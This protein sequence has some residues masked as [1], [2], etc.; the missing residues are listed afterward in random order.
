MI[1]G[2]QYGT[3]QRRLAD[4]VYFAVRKSVEAQAPG[5][6]KVLSEYH[7]ASLE[8]LAKPGKIVVSWPKA[9]VETSLGA[10]NSKPSCETM[11][12]QAYGKR[13]EYAKEL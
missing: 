9:A 8:A 7:Q 5:Y 11:L 13:A 1:L 12:P 6:G 4:K 2:S 3:P 10:G